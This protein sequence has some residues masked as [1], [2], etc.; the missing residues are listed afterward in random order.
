MNPKQTILDKL[1]QHY[2]ESTVDAVA[3]VMEQIGDS[4]HPAW[5]DDFEAFVVEHP[6]FPESADGETE[7]MALFNYWVCITNLL[8]ARENETLAPYV[9]A[10][11]NTDIGK[12]TRGGYRE[13]AGRPS[14]G[15]RLRIYVPSEL[16]EWL[17]NESNL[18]AVRR[19]AFGG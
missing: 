17:K 15:K 14:K 7:D 4:L 5:N 11:I 8:E 19:L 18:E 1:A 2:A 12:P 9:E 10:K 3:Q 16:A 13:G 6:L